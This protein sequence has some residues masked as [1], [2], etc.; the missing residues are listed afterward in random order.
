MFVT[1]NDSAWRAAQDFAARGAAVTI[2]DQRE[3]VDGGLR[4]SAERAGIQFHTSALVICALGG[5]WVDGVQVSRPGSVRGQRIACDL[6]CMS[7]GWA[8][9]VHL[10]SHAGIKPVYQALID[11][12]VPGGYAAGH[13]GAGAVAGTLTLGAAIAEAGHAGVKAAQ[14]AGHRGTAA[15]CPLPETPDEPYRTEPP[16]PLPPA[17]RGRAFVD[18]QSDVTTRDFAIAHQEGFESVEH[19]KRYTTLGMG[20]DQ[21]KTSNLNAIRLMANLRA[22]QISMA[23]TTTFR[24]PYTPVSLGALAGRNIGRRFRPIRRS[25]LHQWHVANGAELIEAGPWL[26]AWYYRWA[27]DSAASSLYRRDAAGAL[28]L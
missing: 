20:T 8:P 11:G 1:N 26:R 14:H 6:V 2:L 4:Q 28:R 9:A 21:G 3:T 25:P 17:A 7:G 13:Y 22:I 18:F 5:R 19:L 10:T 12:F 16:R 15:R 24:P 27:G 23:G